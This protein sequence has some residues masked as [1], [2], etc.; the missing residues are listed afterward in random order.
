MAVR[1]SSTRTDIGDSDS[2]DER[3]LGHDVE[4][5]D[6]LL[7]EVP[8]VPSDTRALGFFFRTD[9]RSTRRVGKRHSEDLNN[10]GHRVGGEESS[11]GSSSRTR[12]LLGRKTNRSERRVSTRFDGFLVQRSPR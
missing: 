2:V 5:L 10:G 3:L 4:R 1:K 6:V 8:Q 9:G 7:H 11:T 12:V